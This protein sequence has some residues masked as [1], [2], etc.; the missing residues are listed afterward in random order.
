MAELQVEGDELV[1]HLSGLEKV[2]AVHPDLRAPLSAVSSIEVLEDA[3]EPADHGLKIGE[4][5]PGVSEVAIILTAGQRL[6]AAVHHNTPR[7]LLIKFQ[8]AQ[9][10]AWIVGCADPEGVLSSLPRR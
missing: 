3:H 10:D 8:G 9:Y 6:F 4:R 5:L 7:G 1:L 2:E